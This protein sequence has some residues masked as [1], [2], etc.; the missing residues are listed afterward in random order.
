MVLPA[1]AGAAL[2]IGSM[3]ARG[4][5]SGGG[6]LR[7]AVLKRTKV[8]REN[9][10]RKKVLDKKVIEKR[11]RKRKESLLEAMKS[12]GKSGISTV[13]DPAKGIFQ[14][15]LEF[16]GILFIGWLV[17]N[18]PK[19]IKWIKDLIERIKRLINAIQSFIDNLGKWFNSFGSV[20]TGFLDNMKNFDFTDQSGKIK[21]AMEGMDSAF[22][23]M[24]NDINNATGAVTGPVGAD[25]SAGAASIDDPNARALL[26]AIAEAEG[27]SRYPNQGYNT[28]FTGTQFTD[29]SK[30]PE[31]LRSGGGY[32]SDAA[33]R[34][35]F[36]STTWNSVMGGAMTPERQDMAALKLA[37][38]RGVDIKNGLSM[39]EIYKLGGEW[40]SIEGGPNMRKGGSYGGQAKYSA[41][42]FLQMYQ[43]YGGKVEGG[44]GG[45]YGSG[46]GGNVTEYLTGDRGHPNFE[47]NGHG[48]QSNYH[49]HIAFRT[50]Q[51]KERAKA[52]LRGAGIQIGSEF[53]PGDDGWHGKDLAIDIPGAQWGG[54]GAI[55]QREFNGSA[56]VRQV[57][58]NAGFGGA[59]LGHGT[60]AISRVPGVSMDLGYSSGPQNMIIVLEEEAPAPMMMGGSSKTS[61]VIVLLNSSV[62]KQLLTSLAYT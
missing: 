24:Q 12:K 18:L 38:R 20:F 21:K 27:T 45:R 4:A 46:G 31:Q 40:A 23:G 58:I 28:Q 43:K 32:T 53:R 61:P 60:N 47:Y 3:F 62:K 37:A 30:H 15:V 50:V 10:A 55:G 36:L 25:A 57:L 48:R 34:Y 14:R 11:R 2:R 26:N 29:L 22:K 54:S 8:R 52:A 39:N 33:G 9:I 13:T 44:S 16:V 1:V 19:I 59:G 17:N 5:K 6:M 56:K 7:K 49:D 51:D 42:S 41:E 35:Q